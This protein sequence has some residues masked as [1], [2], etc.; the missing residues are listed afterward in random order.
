M[1]LGPAVLPS[2]TV[3]GDVD[4]AGPSTLGDGGTV[5]SQPSGASSVLLVILGASDDSLCQF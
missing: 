2:N 5:A 4:T 3:S 1:G